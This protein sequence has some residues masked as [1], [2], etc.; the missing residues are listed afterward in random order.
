MAESIDFNLEV[1]NNNL[2]KA[3][4]NASKKASSL[5]NSLETAIGVFAGGLAL[6]GFDLLQDAISSTI[7]FSEDSIKAFTEQEDALNKLSQALKSS[8]SFSNE[9]LNDFSDFASELQR[10]SKFG[11][12]LVLSQLALAK[13]FGATNAK[14][15]D[16]V[17]AAAELSATF[18]GS[19]EENVAKLGKTLS[20]EVGRLGQ[21]IPELKG[22]TKE[23]LASGAAADIVNQKFSGAASSELNTY[24][25]SIIAVNNAF[26]D[27]QEEIG[28]VLV[29]TLNLSGKNSFLKDV[30]EEL[31]KVVQD[32]A[33][34]QKRSDGS[35]VESDRSIQQLKDSLNE[36]KL[37]YIELEQKLMKPGTELATI[38]NAQPILKRLNAE[39]ATGTAELEK[40]QA[41][42]K[43]NKES[44][45][46]TEVQGAAGGLAPSSQEVANRQ[47]VNN[48]I[49]ALNQQLITEKQNQDLEAYNQG[50]TNENDRNLAE[51][52]RIQ[53]FEIAKAEAKAAIDTA[54]AEAALTGEDERLAVARI[55][56]QKEIEIQRAKGAAIL[57]NQKVNAAQDKKN[58]EDLNKAKIANLQT[59]ANYT[60]GLA[61]L[62]TALA[63]DGSRE[64][65][66][67]N[68]A[69]A[70]AQIAIA[71]ATGI[72]NALFLP[73]PAQPAAIASA[74]ITASLAAA[75]V[76][77][78]AIKGFAAGGVVGQFQG[79]TNGPDNRVATIR[80]GEMILNANQQKNLFDSINSGS[81]GGGD[82][83]IQVDGREIARAVRTQ[84]QRGYQIA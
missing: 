36:T 5:G 7:K 76:V 21:L 78:T 28:G 56:A 49:L 13:S 20:G 71:R 80:D 9:A 84:V 22:L 54:N 29:S 65:F 75:T 50:L 18:G 10:T 26:S 57:A 44:A 3:L 72:A 58:F 61:N 52:A 37:E 73:P 27:L 19:L 82:I 15:K 32:Y 74:N 83:V 33:I 62:G 12:E 69:A 63:K 16:L 14:S 24:S 77:A 47:K 55:N 45:S 1:K 68:K 31:T 8:G 48:E 35:L 60:T 41:A 17:Q 66:I 42:L 34:S 64:Q 51:I 79:A 81:I 11:D 43:S 39:I 40:A 53:E 2:D 59:L 6:K 70:L 23:Q 67:I 46:A 4:D 25:G 30:Y 38:Q